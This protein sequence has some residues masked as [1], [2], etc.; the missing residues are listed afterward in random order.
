MQL[1]EVPEDQA[2]ATVQRAMDLGINHYET[3]RGYGNSE[4]ILGRALKG[5]DRSRFRLT[6]KITPKH[7]QN[8][9]RYIEESLT[10]LQVELVVTGTRCLRMQTT[11][12]EAER[13]PTV[14]GAMSVCRG[15]LRGSI[16][17]P[18]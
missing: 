4:E 3:A 2:I 8:Y 16:Y 1:P 7:Y 15:V 18:Y 12:L 5:F 10:R 13:P 14:Q 11:G 6:T 9:R 17:L